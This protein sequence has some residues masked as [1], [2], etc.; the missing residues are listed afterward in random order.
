MGYLQ[1]SDE[2]VRNVENELD[3]ILQSGAAISLTGLGEPVLV[4]WYNVNDKLSTTTSGTETADSLTGPDSPFRYNRVERQPVFGITKDLQNIEMRLDDNGIADMELEIEPVIPPNTIIPS[5]FDHMIYR[6]GSG[7]SVTF[8]V[9]NVQINTL[10]IQGYYKVPMHLVDIDSDEYF[11]NL[12]KLTVKNLVVDDSKVGTNE[13]CILSDT[14]FEEIKAIN[15][16][17]SQIMSDYIDTFFSRKYNSFIFRGFGN[18]NFTV[19]DPYLT[20][21]LLNHGLMEL[22]DEILQPVVIDQNDNFRGEYNKTVFRA[23]EMRDALRINELLY[24]VTG[25]TKNRV[26]PFAYWGEETVYLIHT[27]L[28]SHAKYPRNNYMDFNWL[29]NVKTIQESR[30]VT[31]L[32]NIII[33]YFKNDT[34][35]KFLAPEELETLKRIAEPEYSETYFYLIPIVLYILSAYKRYLNDNS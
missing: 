14:V 10:R 6:F 27:Y 13:Q 17:S 12:E 3:K 15:K 34:F 24:E 20:W 4:T 23:V 25:F 32:E 9:N 35:E 7:R 1:H 26:N 18:S 28:D 19:Y 21:F 5:P 22:Y 29:Y 2:F 8:R 33:R 30:S 31:I 16:I 11:T